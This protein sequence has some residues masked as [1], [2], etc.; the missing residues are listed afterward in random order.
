M[1]GRMKYVGLILF[2]ALTTTGVCS[3]ISNRNQQ[4][5]GA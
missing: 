3:V 4:F 5:D 2:I 1:Y